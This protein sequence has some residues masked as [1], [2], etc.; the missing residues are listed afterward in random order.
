MPAIYD[1]DAGG[2]WY[3]WRAAPIVRG[4]PQSHEIVIARWN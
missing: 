1:R 3:D 2:L 4:K